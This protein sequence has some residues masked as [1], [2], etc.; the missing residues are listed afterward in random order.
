LNVGLDCLND[1]GEFLLSSSKTFQR[2][3]ILQATF[4]FGSTGNLSTALGS[5]WSVEDAFAWAIGTESE[6]TLPLPG[7]GF[8]YVLRLELH[9]AIFA[10]KVTR[11]RLMIRAGKTV[12]GSF[13]VTARGTLVMPLPTELTSGAERL[14]LTLIHPDAVRPRDHL[15]VDDSRR[16]TLCFH[17][18]SLERPDQDGPKPSDAVT[19][20]PVH[21]VVAGGHTASAICAIISKLP[22]LKRRFGIR[23]LDLSKPLEEA[24]KSL[25]PGTLDTMQFCWVDLSAGRPETRDP[26]RQR[27]A[28][29]CIVRTFY[30]PIIRSFWPFLAPDARRCLNRA[31]TFHPAIPMATVL[32]RGSR[33]STCPTTSST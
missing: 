27:P 1:I 6:L 11:Q 32:R 16:L 31:A 10:P 21:G 17:S 3:W 2:G 25:P 19:L 28:A 22:S 9:P 24:T 4:V 5:G 26:L 14:E 13:E 20:E 29:G 12:L 8:A 15:A 7:D 18:A 23:F 33:R 30:A